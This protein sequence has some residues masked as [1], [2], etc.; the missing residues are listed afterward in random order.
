MKAVW[1][2]YTLNAESIEQISSS[3]QEYMK[4]LG[5]DTRSIQRN[6]LLVEE[7]L[8]RIRDAYETE[9]TLSVMIGRHLGRHVFKISY[10]GSAFDPTVSEGEDD[11]LLETIGLAPS[12]GFRK[13]V[14][15]VSMTI[16]G[17]AKRGR[18]FKILLAIVLAGLF[19]YLGTFLPKEV[20]TGIDDN[21]ILPVM[22]CFL[23]LLSTFAGFMIALTISSG[24]LGIG[25][26][27]V[28][29]KIGKKVI[30]R[31][32]FITFLTSLVA[33]AIAYFFFS[34]SSDSAGQGASFQLKGVLT[35]FFNIVPNN[36]VDPFMTG[37]AL[38]IIVIGL[39]VGVGLLALG[40]KTKLV[41]DFVNEGA[42][43]TQWLTTSVCSVVPFFVFVALLHQVWSDR[44]ALLLSLW[45]PLLVPAGVTVSWV[46]LMLIYV[47]LRTKC[48]PIKILKKILPVYVFATSTGSSLMAF[49]LGMDTCREKLGVDESY[50]KFA[51]PMGNVVYMQGTV[52][53]LTVISL[54]FA[55]AYHINVSLVWF[56]VAVVSAALLSI[57]VPPIPGAAIMLF[58]VL[59]AQLGIPE[60]AIVLAITMDIIMD[61]VDTGINIMMLI[62]EVT[63]GARSMK[64]LDYDVLRS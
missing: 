56:A 2:E 33:L 20:R 7:L 57:A 52:V 10:E 35:M 29:S 49:T 58:T 27:S 8:L 11:V 3:V 4:E 38:Q 30:L 26:M 12:W 1:K 61:F 5:E 37:N 41:R 22:S 21:F 51:Y 63:N 42:S 36:P 9:I 18:L 31:F 60:D 43:L 16:S 13:N 28:L 32:V 34:F 53:Y 15:T 59:F 50:V 40:E 48:S 64:R 62:M 45:R 14:N 25:D 44:V 46:I 55:D 39:F 6:R 19:G 23:G 47:S 17:R 24:V 54:F